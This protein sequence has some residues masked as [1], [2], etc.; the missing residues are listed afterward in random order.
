MKKKQVQFEVGDLVLEHLRKKIFPKRECIK[1]KLKKIGTCNILRKFSVH[2]YELE[3][4]AN[5]GISPILNVV[6]LYPYR[7][8]TVEAPEDV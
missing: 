8:D 3:L 6:D 4:L 5:I 7:G 2:A 1:L